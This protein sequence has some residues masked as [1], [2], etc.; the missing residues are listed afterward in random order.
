MPNTLLSA[1]R[2][3]AHRD[4]GCPHTPLPLAVALLLL[5]AAL[6]W[7]CFFNGL[8]ILY[9]ADKTEALQLEIARQMAVSGDW[10]VPAIDGLTYFDKPPLPYWIGGLLLRLSPQQVWLPRLGAAVA[11]CIGVI[12][13]LALCRFGSPDGASRR[14]LF[15][16]VGAAAILALLP[17]Y[18]AFARTAIHDIYL[19]ASST[20]ALACVF[21]LSQTPRPSP[22]RQAL[23]GG[24]AGIALGVGLLA[25][26]LLSLGL[27]C[28]IAGL[29]LLLAGGTA[30][31]RCLS[32]RF[33]LPLLLALLLVAL[34]WHLA[35]WQSQ[36]TTFLEGYL[37]RSHLGRFTSTLDGHDGPWFYY[38]PVYAAITVPWG[39]TGLVALARA[40]CLNP[41]H[42]RRQ[43][44]RDPL[45]LFCT[46]WIVVSV[47][48]LS[49][50]STKL[51]H[52]IL[53]TLPPTAIAA[54]R[55]FWPAPG[56]RPA[57]ERLSRVLLTLTAGLLLLLALA[58]WQIPALVVP[59]T[60]SGPAF[61]L[62]LRTLLGSAP[63][64]AGLLALGLAAGWAA[65]RG[66]QPHALL[67]GLWAAA[68]LAVLL[69]LAPPVLELYRQLHQGP[70]LE[71][72]DRA[73][74]EARPSEAIQV[75]RKSWYS[76]KIRTQGRAEILK[77]GEA[78]ARYS[79]E[80]P[81]SAC[82]APGLLIGQSRHVRQLTASC[83][84]GSLEILHQDSAAE[85]SLARLGPAGAAPAATP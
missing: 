69:A 6:C 26:G 57:P 35:A 19:T 81:G 29:F 67:G 74:R 21:L 76:I 15:R 13:T 25:K 28:A 78:F 16:A 8:A 61:S 82:P 51:P 66:R 27:P 72:A 2:R 84:S 4:A 31:R 56:D 10:V 23:T 40:G 79:Q 7:V 53:G 24:G 77:K 50:A 68:T 44:R 37:G 45:A 22:R 11:G 20:V 75:L 9:P 62:A 41:R 38:L 58:L 48:L 46:L 42:W 17:A 14:G 1:Q 60:D 54:A 59:L 3:S 33:L 55:F 47:G 73:L 30:V 63:V 83:P 52:Y 18:L 5:L 71:M 64:I 12:A 65:R 80:Q 43:A 36:G 32:V 85:L 49:L 70:R 39:I 34:P